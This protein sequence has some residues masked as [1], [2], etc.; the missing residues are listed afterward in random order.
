MNAQET[1]KKIAA[2]LARDEPLSVMECKMLLGELT[3]V[4][5]M[6]E[7]RIEDIR[8]REHGPGRDGAETIAAGP[9]RLQALR[10]GSIEEVA[11]LDKELG[12]LKIVRS[13]LLAQREPIMKRMEA[14]ADEEAA[15]C[16]PE[17]HAKLNAA[18]DAALAKAQ[19]FKNSLGSAAAALHEVEA[20]YGRLNQAYAVRG[21]TYPRVSGTEE[22]VERINTLSGAANGALCP[23]GFH[24]RALFFLRGSLGMKDNRDHLDRGK[25][26]FFEEAA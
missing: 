8:Q 22:Q 9:V 17:A 16:L 19:E 21:M 1:Q 11:A 24:P 23:P 2:V 5:G 15:A 20:C 25:P 6:V 18:V 4:I 10:F 7:S 26:G 12:E 3:P 14:A 13:Q